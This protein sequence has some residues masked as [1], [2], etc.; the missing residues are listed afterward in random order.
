MDRRRRATVRRSQR[1][2]EDPIERAFPQTGAALIRPKDRRGAII[3]K[4]SS[5]EGKKI[6]LGVDG[7]LSGVV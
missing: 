6:D 7:G 5:M 1:R 3:D 4:S 2:A